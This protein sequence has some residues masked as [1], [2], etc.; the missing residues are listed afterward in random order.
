MRYR[1][2]ARRAR[3]ATNN[4]QG[5]MKTKLLITVVCVLALLL[6]TATPAL[7]AGDTAATSVAVDVVAARPVSFAMTVLGSVLFVASLPVAVPSK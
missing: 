5:A 4:N 6:N 3:A 7:A 1:H 2:L